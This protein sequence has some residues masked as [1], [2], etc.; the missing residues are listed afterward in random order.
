MSLN[1]SAACS[2]SRNS[3]RATASQDTVNQEN[4]KLIVKGIPKD[5]VQVV[6]A[7]GTCRDF[8]AEHHIVPTGQP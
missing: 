1:G 7:Y 6:A 4:D 8:Q 5:L 2:T 3:K